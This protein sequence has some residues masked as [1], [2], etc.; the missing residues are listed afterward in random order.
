MS[1]LQPG[2]AFGPYTI[3]NQIGPADRVTTYKAYDSSQAR[4]VTLKVLSPAGAQSADVAARFERLTQT[5]PRLSHPRLWPVYEAC[6]IAGAPYIA[7][8]D[9]GE[10]RTLAE[11]LAAGPLSLDD[12]NRIISAVA[13]ALQ[14]AH[15]QGIAHSALTPDA[16][17][18]DA[19]DNI[20]LTDFGL[21]RLLSTQADVAADPREDVNA[22]GALLYT[23]VTGEAPPLDNAKLS[24]ALQRLS[25][26]LPTRAKTDVMTGLE[27]VVRRATSPDPTQSFAS[28]AD[29]VATWQPVMASST[30][31][32][33][34]TVTPIPPRDMLKDN[35]TNAA[36]SEPA[37]PMG[38]HTAA[39]NVIAPQREVLRNLLRAIQAVAA[40]RAQQEA[41]R[42]RAA[43]S[44]VRAMRAVPVQ[45][46]TLAHEL[47][48]TSA[49]LQHEASASEQASLR[50]ARSALITVL[51]IFF[52]LL[53]GF[54]AL[55][56]AVILMLPEAPAT[57]T[58]IIAL[59]TRAPS[60]TLTPRSGATVTPR[61]ATVVRPSA[62]PTAAPTL[63]AR[64]VFSDSFKMGECHLPEGDN[65]KRTYQCE[66]GE[67]TMISKN[68]LARWAYYDDEYR[69][70]VAE[71]DAR[72]VTRA[73][74]LEHGLLWRVS[75]DGES[76]YGMT[77]KASGQLAVFRYQNARF[78]YFISGLTLSAF[79]PGT[80]T[81]HL[82]VIAQQNRM[83][84]FL[85]DQSV[86]SFSD[87]TLQ[88]GAVGFFIKSNDPNAKVAF[89]H[90]RIWQIEAPPASTTQ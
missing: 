82:K 12:I 11:R 85:N 67:Y 57:A 27:R 49:A 9:L 63:A 58:P 53:C 40:K 19:N 44:S 55:C 23:L 14:Y 31:A 34:P 56:V 76:L 65:E 37:R 70:I 41:A 6:L 42:W 69:D 2:Q 15:A 25:D 54:P 28:V 16:I 20:A 79:N 7:M 51:V 80:A 17:L 84:L 50:R 33:V 38:T 88:R 68:D 43:E 3:I 21:A 64:L 78:N 62:A 81:N 46:M 30:G 59:D 4:D 86:M 83:S 32:R 71:A 45:P 87:S 52:T 36:S 29:F 13:D 74:S 22:I 8:R 24:E 73:P 26:A 1:I 5:L 10:M 77:L 35:A 90:L 39:Q 66:N 89:S 75:S 47:Q 61:T 72:V 60:A 18:V 48:T